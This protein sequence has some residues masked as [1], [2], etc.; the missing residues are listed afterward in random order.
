MSFARRNRRIRR[1]PATSGLMIALLTTLVF[2]VGSAPTQAQTITLSGPTSSLPFREY[3]TRELGDPWDMSQRTDIGWFT[4]SVDQPASN[5]TSIGIASDAGGNTFFKGQTSTSS[6]S[7]FVL[8]SWQPGSGKLGKIGV[9]HPI[10]TTVYN[11]LYVKMKIANQVLSFPTPPVAQVFWSRDTLFYNIPDHPAATHPYGGTMVATTAANAPVG[12]FLTPCSALQ[13]QGQPECRLEGGNWVVYRIPLTLALMQAVRPD[14]AK[15]HNVNGGLGA[16]WGDPGVTADSLRFSPFN[17]PGTSVGEFQIDWMRLVQEVPGNATTVT[18]TG[19][20]TYDVVVS[21]QAGCTDYSVIGYSKTSGFQ[22]PPQMLPPGTYRVGLRKPFTMNGHTSST[23][24]TPDSC[25]SATFTV[26]AP[27]SLSLTSPNPEGSTDDFAT[28]V[29][30][31]AWDFDSLLDIDFSRDANVPDG[32]YGIVSKPATDLAGNDLGSVRVFRN[33]STAVAGIGDPHIYPLWPIPAPPA[34]PG[35][36]ARGQ[37]NRIDTDKYR[38][39]TAEIG[40]ERTR[41]SAAGSIARIIWH[42][43]GEFRLDNTVAEIE[44]ADIILRHLDP[45][46]QNAGKITLETLQIDMADRA[47]LPVETDVPQPGSGWSN[48]CVASTVT[49]CDPQLNPDFAPGVNLFRFDFHEFSA[50]TPSYIRRLKL[51]AIQ[52][53]GTSFQIQWT[54]SNPNALVSTV[55]LKAV[56][57]TDPASKNYRPLDP[58]CAGG[59]A[60][61]IASGLSLGAGSYNWSPGSTP[62][63]LEGNEY[64]VCAQVFVSGLAAPVDEVISRWPV[65]IET[66]VLAPTPFTAS[67]TSLRYA[68]TK[69]GATLTAVTN[70]QVV[71]VNGPNLAWTASSTQPWIQ[72]TNGAGTGPGVFT[73][74]IVNPGNVIGAQTT[75]NGSVTIAATGYHPATV[76][77]I[78]TVDQTGGANG[79]PPFGTIDTPQA[80]ATGVTG[81]IAVTG[82]AVDDVGVAGV[83][84]YRGCLASLE[85]CETIEGVAVVFVGEATLVSGIRTDI[86]ALYPTYPENYRAAWGYLLLTNLLPHVSNGQLFGGQG[87]ITLYV[88]ARDVE[89]RETWLTQGVGAG[90]TA[91][92]PITLNNE[93]IARPFGAIDTPA[94]GATVS[95]RVANWGWALTPDTNTVGGEAGDILVPVTG[96]TIQV[97]VDGAVWP[98]SV[99]YNL[100]R[101]NPATGGVQGVMPPTA[102]CDDDVASAFGHGTPQPV[103]TARTSN[104]TR[105]RNLDQGR[106]AIGVQ[107]VDTTTLANGLHTIMWGVRD[108]Q[109]RG[110]GV[111]SRF[112]AVLNGTTDAGDAR[113]AAGAASLW[114]APAVVR[115]AAADLNDGAA[116]STPVLGRTGL[117]VTAPLQTLPADGD[118]VRH[119]RLG[120]LDRMELQIGQ[121]DAGYVVANGTRRDLPIGS[122]LDAATGTFTWVPAVGYYGPY[123]LV[124]T[125]GAA[126]TS[127]EV[128]P[129]EVTVG[130]A[131]APDEAVLRMSLDAPQPGATLSGAFVVAG[132]A[133]DPAA[134]IGA[135]IGAIHVW[136]QPLEAPGAAPQFVGM[137]ELG[138]ARADVAAEYGQRF[139]HTGF[140]LTVAAKTLAPGTYALTAYAWNLGTARWEDARTVTITV[141]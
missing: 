44:S 30:G 18:W 60:L 7:F 42:V 109:N 72:V 122:R 10:D 135:G 28:S 126:G 57:V 83:R 94:Q 46:T 127:A 41:D 33:L 38:I 116:W 97:L 34:P 134:G 53:T 27:P 98:G 8:D 31:N 11:V 22:F 85:A 40:V 59:S 14:V 91:A 67:P 51:A 95:G 86:E 1:V 113:P 89:G 36:R 43:D 50:A 99:L 17:I 49:K 6:P 131:P 3:S 107:V 117:D 13:A 23:P 125:R 115:G 54:P 118:G 77:V 5:L 56:P 73:V 88:R 35:T 12:V 90:A 45:A 140:S 108:S 55:T 111:G 81:T 82:W 92:V 71:T 62:G 79:L 121:V 76:P 2:G 4:W 15:W 136:A 112:F 119:V 106:G 65:V 138:G 78:L 124:F 66:Q 132:W 129:V 48:A 128:L 96:T 133:L 123:R 101:G 20:G 100:C 37:Y 9:N 61:T 110:D 25:S 52:R 63:L 80:G 69:S 16:N 26:Q 87:P 104:P 141:R 102:Y 114:A 75:L 103:F 32:T 21:T 68:A 84:L 58:S 39:L 74:T 93:A 105:H 29:L 137:A 24:N 70:P 130:S 47:S 120:P 19:G 64:Y 139:G